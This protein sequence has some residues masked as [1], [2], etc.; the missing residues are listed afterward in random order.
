MLCF[1]NYD[2]ISK[3]G[4]EKME[5]IEVI[6]NR[7]QL[8][9]YYMDELKKVL[10]QNEDLNQKKYEHYYRCL[11]SYL[12]TLWLKDF[13]LDESG[14]LPTGLKRGILSEDAL[15]NL[16]SDIDEKMHKK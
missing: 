16:L 11:A 12:E 3:L 13:E 1:Y 9:E 4:C 10:N 8:Y 5:N 7:I 6:V 14:Y 2:T 15:Y